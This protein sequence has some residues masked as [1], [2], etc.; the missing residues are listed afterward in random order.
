MELLLTLIVG[1]FILI[2]T[3]I[4]KLTRNNDKFV[5]FSISLALG[6]IIS[7]IV[8][9][10]LPETFEL[11]SEAY[12][13]AMTVV[14]IIGFSVLGFLIIM[15]L[16]NLIPNHGHG[17]DSELFHLG[18]VS[19]V[20]IILHNVIEGMAIYA[21]AK[22]SLSMGLLMGIGVGFHNIPMG[23][24]ITSALDKA[25]TSLSKTVT[26]ISS[27]SLSTFVGGLIMYFNNAILENVV[28]LGTILAITQ[29]MLVYIIVFELWPHINHG[30]HKKVNII[31]IILGVL[32][33]F[34]SH[35]L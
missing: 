20:A 31:G 34:I 3:A 1:L 22:N 9:E 17:H 27:I 29:G 14:L 7:L 13:N 8:L 26:I 30:E 24:V 5:D 15:A 10:L 32:I 23:M 21:T 19:S 18:L 11:L 25:K 2:G 4:V 35:L 16:E 6:V 12:S 28:L 33:I